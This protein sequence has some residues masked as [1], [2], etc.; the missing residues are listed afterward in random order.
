MRRG[1]WKTAARPRGGYLRLLNQ[2]NRVPVGPTPT[3]ARS[4][5]EYRCGSKRTV[6]HLGLK[7]SPDNIAGGQSVQSLVDFR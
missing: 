7:K 3:S 1:E 5:E 6:L 4:R 2:A